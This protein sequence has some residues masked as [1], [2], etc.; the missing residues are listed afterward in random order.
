[1]A[2]NF[3]F[4]ASASKAS[5]AANRRRK[6]M[7][8]LSALDPVTSDRLYEADETELLAA[9]ADYQKSTGRRFPTYCEVLAVLRGLGYR[10]LP[11]E[12]C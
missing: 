8:P 7:A 11:I 9:M 2:K 4:K 10:K 1:M 5:A 12:P 3:G 6:E